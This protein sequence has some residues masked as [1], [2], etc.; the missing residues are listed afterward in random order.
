MADGDKDRFDPGLG[1]DHRP[2]CF[3]LVGQQREPASLR[4]RRFILAT[5]QA[6]GATDGG[7][8]N[9]Q[10]NVAGDAQAAG[11]GQPLPIK[12]KQVRG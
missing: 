6:F 11:M 8:V 2:D 7:D 4:P 9:Q 10:A 3:T 1:A 5:Q 12:D